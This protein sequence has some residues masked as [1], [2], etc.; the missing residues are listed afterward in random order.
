MKK[1]VHW[2]PEEFSLE[3]KAKKGPEGVYAREILI[4]YKRPEERKSD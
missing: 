4:P 2:V 3:E 1:R